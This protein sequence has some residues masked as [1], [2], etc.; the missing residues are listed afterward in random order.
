MSEKES[1]EVTKPSKTDERNLVEQELNAELPPEEKIK[2]WWERNRAALALGVIIALLMVVGFQGLRIYRQSFDA[3]VQEAWLAI[4][5]EET[6]L[7]FAESHGTHP[8][9]SLA[10]LQLADTAYGE[11]DY[12][13]ANSYYE[14]AGEG[15]AEP[16]FQG[17]ARLG[18]AVTSI[19]TGALDSGKTLLEKI[20]RDPNELQ[21]VRAEAAYHRAILAI[22]EG[23]PEV[24]QTFNQLL[25]SLG[26]SQG[27]ITRLE[28]ARKQAG[29]QGSEPVEE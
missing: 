3:K 5:S 2:L 15:A 10:Y 26:H 19:H 6:R 16:L 13:T 25:F 14:Q 28:T 11:G 12:E 27:W 23:Q 20:A 1:K 24:F 21:A 17:R 7:A 18:Y 8:L 22:E 29:F 4:D 9:G